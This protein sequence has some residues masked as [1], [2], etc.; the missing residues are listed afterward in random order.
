LLLSRG[1]PQTTLLKLDKS[2]GTHKKYIFLTF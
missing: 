1:T 2:E